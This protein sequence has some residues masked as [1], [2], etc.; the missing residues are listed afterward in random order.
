MARRRRR[1]YHRAVKS[2]VIT[3]ND[4]QGRCRPAVVYRRRGRRKRGS[5]GLRQLDKLV[6]RVMRAE[7]SFS[8]SYLARHDR[9]NQRRK[10]GWLRD[11]V[12]NTARAI[13]PAARK[14]TR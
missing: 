3:G 13:A 11:I 2:I 12:S 14:I 7:E 9:S 6:R 8:S 4:E 10:D 5:P 1:K